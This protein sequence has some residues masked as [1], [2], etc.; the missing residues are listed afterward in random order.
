VAELL[1]TP[2]DEGTWS[3]RLSVVDRERLRKV[4]KTVH[5]AH[6]PTEKI[7]DYEA[8][9]LIDAMGPATGEAIIKKALDR[10]LV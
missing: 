3:S 4:V 5:F 7:T 9:K 1:L 6:Y 8:D 2:K 10:G